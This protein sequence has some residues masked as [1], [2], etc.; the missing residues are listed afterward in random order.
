MHFFKHLRVVLKHKRLVFKYSIKAGIPFRGLIHDLSKFSY[1]EFH[2]SSK[3]FVG[4]KSPTIYEREFKD[5]VSDICLH[6]TGRNK[7]HWQYWVDFEKNKMVIAK[8]PYKICVEFVCDMISASKT[9]NPSNFKFE[10]VLDYFLKREYFYIMH[11]ACKE[12]VL[13]CF[14]G[15]VSDGI[16]F[17]KKKNTKELY[18]LIE[19]KYEN[20]IIIPIDNIIYDYT[21]IR[22]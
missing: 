22:G 9:Y 12:F 16:K 15:L 21:E 20:T 18:K 8:M 11:P 14:K 1:T 2:N 19:T 7:H 5:G 4:T 13:E 17:I 3:Y 6:H 10:M